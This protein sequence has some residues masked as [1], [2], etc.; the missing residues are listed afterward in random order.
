M[1]SSV[2]G[3]TLPAF[4]STSRKIEGATETLT[5]HVSVLPGIEEDVAAGIAAFG[6]RTLGIHFR[7][8]EMNRAPGHP[9]GPTER[10]IIAAIQAMLNEREF[11]RIFLVTED[12]GYADLLRRQFGSLVII[13][14]SFRTRGENAYLTNPRPRHRYLLGREILVD[15]LLLSRCQ[16]LISGG[17]NVVEFAKLFN[18]N[19]FEAVWRI[20]NGLNVAN[21]LSALFLFDIRRRLPSGLGGLPGLIIKGGPQPLHVLSTESQ[22]TLDHEGPK[23]PDYRQAE[24]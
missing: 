24:T 18:G 5:K 13:T 7:G 6:Q 10:Q 15:A 21:P 19:Q 22:A 4:A 9:F 2:T 16:A 8:Q 14:D 1:S 11:D 12:S 3:S 23:A 17:S 20:A